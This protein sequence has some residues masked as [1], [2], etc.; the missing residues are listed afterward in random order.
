MGIKENR[1]RRPKE[2]EIK[3]KKERTPITKST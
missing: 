1:K 3:R 2:E